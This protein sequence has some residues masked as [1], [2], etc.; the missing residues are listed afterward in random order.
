MILETKE[1][2]ESAILRGEE[3]KHK[4]VF[5]T[6]ELE[7]Q[8]MP[9][10]NIGSY[11][12]RYGIYAGMCGN[13]QIWVALHDAPEEMNWE[14]AKKY[15]EDLDAD[16]DGWHLPTKEELMLI[17]ANKDIINQALIEHGGEPMKEDWYWSSSEYSYYSA[18]GQSF[19]DGYV[20]HY[21]KTFYSGYVR[22]VL[23]LSI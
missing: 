11:D 13:K 6:G 19:S 16:C 22:P 5:Y 21:S 17:F 7:N 8:E 10:W 14:E 2:F 20:S 4:T 1:A 9:L 18:W 12:A 23:A 15:C 3:I